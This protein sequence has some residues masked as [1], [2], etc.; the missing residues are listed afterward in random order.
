VGGFPAHYVRTFHRRLE[1]AYGREVFFLYLPTEEGGGDRSYEEGSLPSRCLVLGRAAAVAQGGRL[2]RALARLDP[3]VV[4]T[5]GHR[6]L[7]VLMASLWAQVSGRKVCY[8][9]D[10]NLITILREGPLR[11]GLR[12]LIL[13]GYL[14]RMWALLHTGSRTKAFYDW[15]LGA[16]ARQIL[17][18]RLPY[19]HDPAPFLSPSRSDGDGPA[20]AGRP[21]AVL[22]V[23]RLIELKRIDRLLDAIALLPDAVRGS[24]QCV[25]AGD[26]TARPGL[27]E[28]ARRLRI[29]GQTIFLG[30][31][32][33]SEVPRLFERADV[34]VLPSDRD[35]W[36]LVINEALTAMT[37]VITPYWVGAAADLVIDGKTGRVL[38]DNSAAALARAITDMVERRTSLRRMGEAGRALV[39]EQKWTLE[40]ALESWAQLRG[41]V[42]DAEGGGASR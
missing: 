29:E 2:I 1:S 24:V 22:Y 13:R 20:T 21:F 8:W 12:R 40:G 28:R 3:A 18:L 33:S 11:L 7:A 31:I 42:G 4:V 38:K 26:G 17:S 35:A 37:P 19:P 23:G 25:L 14:G 32:P 36:G 6:P 15:C 9:A 39:L 27:E 5:A 41:R 10:T 16:R 30:A 34:L